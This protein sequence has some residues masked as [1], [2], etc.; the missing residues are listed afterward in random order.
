MLASFEYNVQFQFSRIV[1]Y[2]M[3]T[4]EI[5]TETLAPAQQQFSRSFIDKL[6]PTIPLAP[7]RKFTE[8]LV[9][10]ATEVQCE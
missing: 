6:Q 9:H 2:Q 5:A 7:L 1:V 10:M 3:R 8:A 4:L